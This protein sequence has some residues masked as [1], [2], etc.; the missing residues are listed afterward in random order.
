M[1][2]IIKSNG[3]YDSFCNLI[4]DIYC[5]TYQHDCFEN[6]SGRGKQSTVTRD[7]LSVLA[8]IGE[9][10]GE[11]E[12]D[13]EKVIQNL[14][15]LRDIE[16]EK[17]MTP[18]V[19]ISFVENNETVSDVMGRMPIM[20]YGRM[21]VMDSDIDKID[22]YVVRSEILRRAADDDFEISMKKLRRNSQ[23]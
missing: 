22:G 10:E 21:P 12:E 11:I 2:T 3:I 9:E 14:L 19:V 17:I 15:K 1:E 16:V 4:V 6:A 13:E 20:T 8:D 7:E 5:H 23:M 18:R